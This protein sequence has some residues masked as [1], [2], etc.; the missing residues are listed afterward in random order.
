MAQKAKIRLWGY[1][2]AWFLPLLGPK[3]DHFGPIPFGGLNMDPWMVPNTITDRYS[4]YVY[5]VMDISE[6]SPLLYP[7]LHT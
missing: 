3:M 4:Y 7:P 2:H 5:M 1:P 6:E